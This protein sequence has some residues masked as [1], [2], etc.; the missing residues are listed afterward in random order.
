MI[1][2]TERIDIPLHCTKSSRYR[3]PYRRPVVGLSLSKKL[4]YLT[5]LEQ[6]VCLDQSKKLNGLNCSW[7]DFLQFLKVLLDQ[8]SI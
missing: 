2:Q 3:R 8:I 5:L 7:G 1:H 4:P 6:P